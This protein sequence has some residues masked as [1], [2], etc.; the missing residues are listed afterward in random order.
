MEPLIRQP[1]T[2]G[3]QA[4]YIEVIDERYHVNLLA[5]HFYVPYA[6][7]MGAAVS[8]LA[9]V[10][11][12]AHPDYP[13]Q[14][15]LALHAKE[16]YDIAF[17]CTV[18]SFGE[19]FDFTLSAEWLDDS[20]ALDGEDVTESVLEW[21]SAVLLRPAVDA[22]GFSTPEFPRLKESFLRYLRMS[23]LDPA[24]QQDQRV[25]EICFE[26]ELS[27]LPFSGTPEEAETLTPQRLY[28]VFCEMRRTAPV[29]A[30]STLSRGDIPLAGWL[31]DLFAGMQRAP[32]S[33][34]ADQPSK[35]HTP[36]KRVTE[37]MPELTG[38]TI[39]AVYKY[40]YGGLELSDFAM[41]PLLLDGTAQS[42]L[43]QNVREKHSVCYS[44][45]VD[46]ESQKHTMTIVCKTDAAHAEEA[47]ALICEQ[48]ELLKRDEY[49]DSLLAAINETY[50][51]ERSTAWDSFTG[52]AEVL[53]SRAA[54]GQ[55]LYSSFA[56]F[57]RVPA[58][59]ERSYAMRAAQ[60][61]HLDTLYISLGGKAPQAEEVDAFED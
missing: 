12:Y 57:T 42:L 35:L 51:S 60:Q 9:D 54:V 6:P 48:I 1:V 7:G 39:Y 18:A 53:L 55:P 11:R 28:E 24:S 44:C 10:I 56:E 25:N 38:T 59:D 14:R 49:P 29:W 19:W 31:T 58:R 37:Q 3:E 5:L 20:F 23:A 47:A 41:I 33:L 32:I 34:I 30:V 43:F 46:W 50:I 36:E 2:V 27:A 17:D 22:G 13:T 8:L 26:G 40:D 16:L 61:L 4:S 52:I 45:Y 15:S 21:L